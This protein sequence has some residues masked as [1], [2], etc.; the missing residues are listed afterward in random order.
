FFRVLYDNNIFNKIKAQLVADHNV[1]S[2]VTRSQLIDDY[3]T[4]AY[5]KYVELEEALD[6][7]SYLHKEKELVV[8][9]AVFMQ[10]KTAINM[11][12]DQFDGIKVL[13]ILHFES[14]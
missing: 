1:F 6:L 13:L 3:F 5:N 4:L 8:W 2:P 12:G 7:M 9:D 11:I 10:L 14:K